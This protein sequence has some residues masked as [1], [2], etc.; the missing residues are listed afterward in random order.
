MICTAW[1]PQQER[2]N[3]NA[4][5]NTRVL[6]T[7]GSGPN[8]ALGWARLVSKGSHLRADTVPSFPA[9]HHLCICVCVCT[10]LNMQRGVFVLSGFT[11][12]E[13]EGWLTHALHKVK[14]LHKEVIK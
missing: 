3:L 11:C 10:Y 2:T 7:T 14:W 9:P 4:V 12:M 8:S 5:L 13:S 6:K 1:P